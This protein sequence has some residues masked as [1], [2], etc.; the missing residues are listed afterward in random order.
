MYGFDSLGREG[1][2]SYSIVETVALCLSR[3]ERGVVYFYVA[4]V[5]PEGEGCM[6]DVPCSSCELGDGGEGAVC[7][8]GEG[9]RGAAEFDRCHG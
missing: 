8:P 6:K 4:L 2:V 9:G 5:F 7:D 3:F 1:L